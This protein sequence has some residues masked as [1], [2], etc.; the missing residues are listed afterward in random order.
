MSDLDKTTSP[1]EC[2]LLVAFADISGFAREF[3]NRTDREMFDLVA[4]FY[5][6]VS[7]AVESSGG[8]VVKYIG[9]AALLV[10][11]AEQARPAVD[12]L[13]QLKATADAWLAEHGFRGELRVRAHIGSVV[14]GPLGPH[15]DHRFDVIGKTVNTAACLPSTGFTLSPELERQIDS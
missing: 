14:C 3:D 15:H 9:D 13:R 6:L 11:P 5:D 8:L 2:R 10:Y 4:L 7:N 12:A 1:L